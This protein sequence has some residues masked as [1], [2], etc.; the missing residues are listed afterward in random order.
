MATS[1]K[2]RIA[3]ILSAGGSM[4]PDGAG[5]F[6]LFGANGIH[7]LS[8]KKGDLGTDEETLKFFEDQL[9]GSD[10]EGIVGMD[11][12]GNVYVDLR[13]Q[14]QFG[15]REESSAQRAGVQPAPGQ[16]V[17]SRFNPN[18][19]G[20]ARA[21]QSGGG[22][23]GTSGGGGRAPAPG[24]GGSGSLARGA[25]A[26]PFIDTGPNIN[27][28]N[29]A[30]GAGAFPGGDGGFIDPNDP[31][32]IPAINPQGR[33]GS[34]YFQPGG[35]LPSAGNPFAGLDENSNLYD[36]IAAMAGG[37]VANQQ[38]ALDTLGG[39]FRESQGGVSEGQRGLIGDL[40]ANPYSLDD[41]TLNR[42]MGQNTKGIN[43]R[44]ARAMM[45]GQQS[46]AS[47]G[48][49]PDS[50]L[51]QA[52]DQQIRTQAGAQAQNMESQ[53][54]IQQAMQNQVDLRS[55]LQV[56]GN[57]ISQDLGTR[58]RLA[59][60]AATGVL[61]ETAIKGDAYLSAALLGAQGKGQNQPWPTITDNRNLT[62]S[63]QG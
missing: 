1:S 53:A 42:I 28:P 57:A 46:R 13:P 27:V 44:A 23:G 5:G 49:R 10:S 45:E 18:S 37:Q 61:G 56:G 51:A 26:N 48:I 29:P 33:P 12:N 43:D 16:A 6:N 47:A 34:E 4:L 35:G 40:Q 63:A 19:V 39:V 41:A 3:S 32:G 15:E 54:R 20:A 30:A 55:A 58:E 31:L 11:A 8:V 62:G 2:D 25:A 9:Q 36:V 59:N 24:G 50:G 52:Q 60:T 22:G 17:D 7:S 38:A 14:G 21:R